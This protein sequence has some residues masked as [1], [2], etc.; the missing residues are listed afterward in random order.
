M[1]QSLTHRFLD[2]PKSEMQGSIHKWGIRGSQILKYFPGSG[3]GHHFHIWFQST[4]SCPELC[5][6]RTPLI[7]QTYC[8]WFILINLHFI[9][10]G[11]HYCK[12]SEEEQNN[13]SYVSILSVQLSDNTLMHTFCIMRV[14][15]C[16]LVLQFLWHL[17]VSQLIWYYSVTMNPSCYPPNIFTD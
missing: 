15:N 3:E 8:L 9:T 16:N 11:V 4:H 10:S 7:S 12:G 17:H 6:V 2:K 14:V 13:F 1:L 5:T